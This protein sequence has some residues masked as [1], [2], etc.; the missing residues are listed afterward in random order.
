MPIHSPVHGSSFFRCGERDSVGVLVTFVGSG[1]RKKEEMGGGLEERS[2]VWLGAGT[3]V[4]VAGGGND[5]C[6]LM[7]EST[8][9]HVGS[10]KESHLCFVYS[11]C[12]LFF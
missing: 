10:S 11:S 6:S 12:P 3:G 2:E 1:G 8:K 4:A 7:L 9:L 5:T